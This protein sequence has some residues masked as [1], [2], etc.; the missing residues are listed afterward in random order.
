MHNPCKLF[1]YLILLFIFANLVI[2][3]LGDSF[4]KII[5]YGKAGGIS[6][7]IRW[8][9]GELAQADYDFHQLRVSKNGLFSNGTEIDQANVAT[10]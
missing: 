9:G 1:W 4:N 5:D 8:F 3:F 6:P 10:K 7:T 2:Q